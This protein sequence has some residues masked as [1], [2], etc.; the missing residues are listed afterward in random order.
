MKLC[1]RCRIEKPAADFHP[2]KLTKDGLNSWCRP[3]VSEDSAARQKAHPERRC[4]YQKRYYQK[5]ARQICERNEDWRKANR[6]RVNQ[7][8]REN[9]AANDRGR[10]SQRRRRAANPQ[11]TRDR[12]NAA[13][14]AG[15]YDSLVGAK[16]RRQWEG[17]VGYTVDSLREWIE[18]QFEPGM[19]WENYGDWHIDHRVPIAA[20][21]F[22]TP[23]DPGFRACWSLRNLRPLWAT[24]NHKKGAKCPPEFAEALTILA[25]IRRPIDGI[26]SRAAT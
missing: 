10:E 21:K 26:A 5:N 12:L 4:K 6:D 15:I 2:H 17:L 22:T 7:R 19:S 23:D 16:G 18:F 25:R 11:T 9:W 13:M 3:C 14:R 8:R 24:E 1:R 20:F